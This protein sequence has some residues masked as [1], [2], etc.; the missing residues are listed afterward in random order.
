MGGGC[1]HDQEIGE[2]ETLAGCG[3]LT[4]QQALYLRDYYREIL[5]A[6]S[7]EAAL[8][9]RDREMLCFED[10]ALKKAGLR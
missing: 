3:N 1:V 7:K 6:P 2:G 8:V 10:E 5:A 9:I 4:L